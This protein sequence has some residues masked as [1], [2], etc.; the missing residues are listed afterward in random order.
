MLTGSINSEELST[1]EYSFPFVRSMSTV[2]AADNAVVN[3]AAAGQGGQDRV[4][5]PLFVI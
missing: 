3:A 5:N 1:P 4:L 2:A